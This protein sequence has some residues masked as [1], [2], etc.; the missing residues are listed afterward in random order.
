MSYYCQSI[1]VFLFVLVVMPLSSTKAVDNWGDF[2]P[3]ADRVKPCP[4]DDRGDRKCNHDRTHRVCAKLVDNTNGQ[5]KRLQ[6]GTKN[7]WEITDQ[8]KYDW[9]K[10][11]CSDKTRSGDPKLDGLSADDREHW[12]ICMWATEGLINKVGCDN[13]HFQCNATDVN[14]ILRAYN[15]D[16]DVHGDQVEITNAKCCMLKKCP[17]F[18]TKETDD[19]LKKDGLKCPK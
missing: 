18:V 9:S 17:A 10:L 13:V 19:L 1:L 14:Y 16:Y 12:C 5:C 4:G 8:V 15:M 7:F 11:I 2:D 6:W 3:Y